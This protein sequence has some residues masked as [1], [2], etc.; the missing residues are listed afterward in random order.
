MR[1][2]RNDGA[3]RHHAGHQAAVATSTK[4]KSAIADTMPLSAAAAEHSLMPAARMK[5]RTHTAHRCRPSP[6]AAKITAPVPSS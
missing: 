3:D 2:R 4:G 1:E 6:R 5:R